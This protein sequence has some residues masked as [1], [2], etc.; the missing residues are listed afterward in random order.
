MA[1]AFACKLDSQ[2]TSQ[3]PIKKNLIPLL[4]VSL[5]HEAS[6]RKEKLYLECEKEQNS[7]I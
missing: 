1:K 3:H 5:D 4:V 7:L 2:D 6:Q